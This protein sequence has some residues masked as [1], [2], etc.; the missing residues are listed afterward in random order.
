MNARLFESWQVQ[1]RYI[2]TFVTKAGYLFVFLHAW[3]LAVCLHVCMFTVYVCWMYL[4]NPIYLLHYVS[5]YFSFG[6]FFVHRRYNGRIPYINAM[7]PQS[8]FSFNLTWL[9]LFQCRLSIELRFSGLPAES[10][11]PPRS[12]EPDMGLG[13]FGIRVCWMVVLYTGTYLLTL[14]AQSGSIWSRIDI[15]KQPGPCS[16]EVSWLNMHEQYPGSLTS[17]ERTSWC[18]AC[19]ECYSDL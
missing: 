16:F 12:F 19:A 14:L 15:A 8:L 2:A 13:W 9:K 17:F 5:M 4:S 3:C 1:T 11:S 18:V 6:A 10:W 7:V